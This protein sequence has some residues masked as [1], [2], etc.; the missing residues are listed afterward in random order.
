MRG[1]RT[2]PAAKLLNGAGMLLRSI[3]NA[4]RSIERYDIHTCRI[5]AER[6]SRH[7]RRR[8]MS[9]EHPR[10][11]PRWVYI[12]VGLLVAILALALFFYYP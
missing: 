4:R 8:R 5:R 12:V 2:R 7:G 6:P 11:A 3:L 10:S 1:S 9:S